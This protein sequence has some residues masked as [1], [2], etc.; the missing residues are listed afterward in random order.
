MVKGFPTFVGPLCRLFLF[1][2][3]TTSL[4]PGPLFTNV[5]I[6][7]EPIEAGVGRQ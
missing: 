1:L 2:K 3:M 4:D 7:R 5:G 6:I